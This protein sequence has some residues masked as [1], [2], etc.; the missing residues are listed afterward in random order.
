M[1]RDEILSRFDDW[2]Q[3]RRLQ[4]ADFWE[5][6]YECFFG[7]EQWRVARDQATKLTGLLG[8]RKGQ[9]V[10]DVCC[11]PGRHALEL[12]Q[13]GVAVT[14]VDACGFL[15]QRARAAAT[16][17]CA[18]VEFVQQDVRDFRRP[19]F[20]DGAFNL[21]TSF[22][23]SPDVRDDCQVLRNVAAS[24]KGGSRF[25]LEVPGRENIRR[26]F[27]HRDWSEQN[28]TFFL[29]EKTP[30]EDWT[31][32]DNRW[33]VV[34]QDRCLELRFG[35]KLYSVQELERMFLNSGFDRVSACGSLDG[36]RYSHEARGIVIVGQKVVQ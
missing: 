12:A 18:R 23:Y 20:F 4:D 10:L 11:G 9:R 3:S 13:L 14:A 28:G 26:D 24:L 27:F 16:A 19:G 7:P 30:S 31:W 35:H 34:R 33:F 22:G 36:D 6:A 15:I 2:R 1:V 32:L 8:L 29:Q 25:V 5:V 21:Y 17:H